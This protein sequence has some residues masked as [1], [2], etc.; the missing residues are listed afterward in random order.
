MTIALYIYVKWF[1]WFIFRQKFIIFT[2][3]KNF[4][5]LLKSFKIVLYTVITL[6]QGAVKFLISQITFFI[7][8]ISEII[9]IFV[10]HI[11][12]SFLLLAVSIKF[13]TDIGN[14]KFFI[15]LIDYYLKFRSL[16]LPSYQFFAECIKFTTDVGNIQF[17]YSSQR[18]IFKF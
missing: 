1:R 16:M 3:T 17:L 8:F 11:S 4:H 15:R 18:L 9:N 10:H 12:P 13:T 7:I 14:I 2:S 6:T 5:F